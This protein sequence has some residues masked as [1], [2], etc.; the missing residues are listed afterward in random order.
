MNLVKYIAFCGAASRREA[1]KLIRAGKVQ[2]CG[3]AETNPAHRLTGEEEVRLHGK[4]LSPPPKRSYYLLN[5]PRGYTCSNA[6]S[7]AEHLAVELFRMPEK[8]L[9][10]AGRLDKESEGAILFSDDG[11]FINFLAHPRY[12]ILKRYEVETASPLSP[13]V[14]PKMCAGIRDQ[15]EILRV[16]SIRSLGKNRCEIL[17]NEGKK[18]EIRRL[19]A[20]FGAPTVTLRRVAVGPVEL[21]ELPPGQYRELSEKELRQFQQLKCDGPET[22]KKESFKKA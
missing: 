20:A 15:G 10:S 12:G 4:V 2:V 1:E 19:T 6:D 13:A 11:D 17:L 22:R 21:G 9:V 8:H 18:R 7:H 16:E 3:V 5:K 14:F